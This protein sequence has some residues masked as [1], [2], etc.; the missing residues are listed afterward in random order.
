MPRAFRPTGA[1]PTRSAHGESCQSEPRKLAQGPG[2]RQGS[3]GKMAATGHSARRRCRPDRPDRTI[4]PRVHRSGE[5]RRFSTWSQRKKTRWGL[6]PGRS[7][8]PWE[9]GSGARRPHAR[10]KPEAPPH[11][12]VSPG[13]GGRPTRFQK[14]R[15]RAKVGG[16]VDFRLAVDW[17]R[18]GKSVRLAFFSPRPGRRSRRWP[19]LSGQPMPGGARSIGPGSDAFRAGALQNAARDGR[20]VG[21]GGIRYDASIVAIPGFSPAAGRRFPL[22]RRRRSPP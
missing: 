9:C 3:S 4:R 22:S 6:R 15:W 17:K 5:N 10:S 21:R 7:I 16:V 2:H 1:P 20:R 8:L 12:W 14:C 11:V 19:H 13:G 18:R